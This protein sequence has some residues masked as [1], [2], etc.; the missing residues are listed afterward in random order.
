MIPRSFRLP[1]TRIGFLLRKGR[2]LANENLVLR[3]QH[4]GFQKVHSRFA[5]TVGLKVYPKAVKRNRLRRQIYEIIRLN[6]SLL[7]NPVD[8]MISTKPPITR[9]TS[10][11]TKKI[12]ITL[13][14][15][16]D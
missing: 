9:L 5:V 7:K 11:Q 1:K 2:R 8:M 3:Y 6:L 16:I 10:E 13:L 4:G 14:K 12:I 15:K